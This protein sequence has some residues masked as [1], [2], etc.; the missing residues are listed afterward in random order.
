MWNI[1]LLF[2]QVVLANV[3]LLAPIAANNTAVSNPTHTITLTTAANAEN[4]CFTA[5]PQSGSEYNDAQPQS[6]SE[7]ND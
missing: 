5:Q 3:L 6:G 7:Y 1:T 2:T 4:T